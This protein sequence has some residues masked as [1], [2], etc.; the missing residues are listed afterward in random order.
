MK[1]T[2][3][4]IAFIFC[5]TF[6]INA[7]QNDATT[8]INGNF[9]S[10]KTS[11]I[12]QIANYNWDLIAIIYKKYKNNAEIKISW[13]FDENQDGI[14]NN[15]DMYNDFTTTKAKLA[16]KIVELKKMSLELKKKT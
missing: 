3:L 14:I 4:S 9:Y 16:A 7:Q 13:M 6:S 11:K 12:K 5:V 15:N 2:I 10:I 8:I 1:N